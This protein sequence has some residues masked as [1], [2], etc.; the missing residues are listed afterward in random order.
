M[1]FDLIFFL[2]NRFIFRS[3]SVA[4]KKRFQKQEIKDFERKRNGFERKRKAHGSRAVI[5]CYPL[6]LFNFENLRHKQRKKT[7]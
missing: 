6:N 2:R 3:L 4:A 1:V 5:L 7:L